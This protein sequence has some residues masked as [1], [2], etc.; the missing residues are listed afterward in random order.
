MT[1]RR[2]LA[3]RLAL[4]L[5]LLSVLLAGQKRQGAGGTTCRRCRGMRLL[6]WGRGMR[7]GCGIQPDV[8]SLHGIPFSLQEQCHSQGK[9]MKLLQALIN[10]S[11]PIN[12][13]HS[14]SR[15]RGRH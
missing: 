8:Y 4:V 2:K 5:V 12:R 3:M 7:T 1:R 13:P 14:N 11:V 9:P 6:K 15:P 10:S